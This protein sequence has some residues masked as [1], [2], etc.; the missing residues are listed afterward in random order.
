MGK[1]IHPR[2][3]SFQAVEYT[4]QRNR[5]VNC[6]RNSCLLTGEIYIFLLPEY[7][8]SILSRDR[9]ADASGL[10]VSLMSVISLYAIRLFIQSPHRICMADIS[11]T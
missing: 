11:R 3:L 2:I 10:F 5:V 9:A 7:S 1:P 6:L 8:I 4:A